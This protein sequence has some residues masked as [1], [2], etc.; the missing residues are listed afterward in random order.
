MIIRTT[1]QTVLAA[2]S[3]SIVCSCVANES[4]PIAFAEAKENGKVD[5]ALIELHDQFRQY[6]GSNQDVEQFVA[7]N[8]QLRIVDGYVLIDAV[9]SGNTAALENQLRA[10]GAT[11][12]SSHGQMVSGF[13]PIAGTERLAGLASL[14]FA[15]PAYAT[16]QPK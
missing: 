1:L 9:A 8:T 16:T 7:T 11:H 5:H 14:K 3:I 12:L 6:T 13:F 4:Q 2:L 15:R 10:M